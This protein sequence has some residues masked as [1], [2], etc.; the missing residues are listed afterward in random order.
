MKKLPKYLNILKINDLLLIFLSL[1]IFFSSLLYWFTSFSFLLLIVSFFLTTVSLIVLNKYQLLPSREKI[2]SKSNQINK[3]NKLLLLAFFLF[4]GA[5]ILELMINATSKSLISPWEVVGAHFFFFYVL[6]LV[7]LFFI[8]KEN[9][10]TKKTNLLLISIHLFLSLSVALIIYRLGYGFDPFIHQG[11]ME[12]IAKEGEINPKTPYYLGQYNLIVSLNYL[13]GISIAFL[14]KILVPLLAAFLLPSTVANL[15]RKIINHSTEK[16]ELIVHYSTI[17]ATA[18]AFSLFIVTTPQNL[19]YLFLIIAI[20]SGLGEERPTKTLIFA[21]AT[22]AIHPISGIPAFIWSGWL[23][24]KA[25][26]H[27]LSTK[28]QKIISATL[29]YLGAV[30]IPLALFISSGAKIINL[31]FSFNKIFLPLNNIISYKY[32]GS[33]DW[34]LNLTYLLFNNYSLLLFILIISGIIIFQR[35]RG[36]LRASSLKNYSW[37]GLLNVNIS[38]VIAYILSVQINFPELINYEQGDFANRI[39]IIILLFLSPFA[40]ITIAQLLKKIILYHKP[41]LKI[42]FLILAL[43][44]ISASLYLAYPR[45]DKYHNSRGYSTSDNDIEAVK[46]VAGIA[47]NNKYIVLANQQVSAAALKSFGFDNYYPSEYG[48]IFFYPIPTGGTL[49]QYYLDMVYKSPSRDTMQQA[50]AL[51]GAKEAYLIINSY[52]NDSG[53]IIKAA[54]LSADNYFEIGNKDI[55]IFQYKNY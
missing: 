40:L 14:N 6:S 27:R 1:F 49:Y 20:F 51:V 38:L 34:L 54:K 36:D 4:F 50:M 39:L 26:R 31:K 29:L 37:R 15:L 47:Q 53:K 42:W 5:A 17:I 32:A 9:V 2:K 33:E 19:S 10:L 8:I 44:F 24:F 55:F 23:L 3:K 48:P 21:L 30:I 41:A 18:L 11:A 16:K 35:N 46:T 25:Y 13:S 45:I 22:A 12:M 7:S 52:W 28:G 43:F